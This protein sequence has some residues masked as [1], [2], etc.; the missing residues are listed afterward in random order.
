METQVANTCVDCIDLPQQIF[1]LLWMDVTEVDSLFWDIVSRLL[2]LV[3]IS[4]KVK[5]HALVL[6]GEGFLPL[7]RRSKN[8]FK[9]N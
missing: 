5:L 7:V 1:L 3:V 9:N 6:E 4:K 8:V 2:I